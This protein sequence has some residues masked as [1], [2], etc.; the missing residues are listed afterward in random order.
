MQLYLDIM[1]HDVLVR[2][3]LIMLELVM[4]I[5]HSWSHCP[6]VL[7]NHL[8]AGALALQCDKWNS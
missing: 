3:Q 1:L 5:D 4:A 8:I 7:Q 2:R 6:L